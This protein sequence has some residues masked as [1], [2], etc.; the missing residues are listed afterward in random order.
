MFK[1]TP[2]EQR[3]Y[4]DGMEMALNTIQSRGLHDGKMI[5]AGFISIARGMM[6]QKGELYPGGMGPVD[7]ESPQKG[8]QA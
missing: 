6:E 2:D 5:I 8:T 7:M 1:R 3:A 4:I